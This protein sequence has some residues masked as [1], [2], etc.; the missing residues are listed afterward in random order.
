MLLYALIRDGAVAEF[1][2]LAEPPAA[3]KLVDGLPMLRPVVDEKP[4]TFDGKTEAMEGPAYIVEDARVVRR[5]TKRALT[6]EELD[7]R[8]EGRIDGADR[9]LFEIAFRQ[10][11]RLR[12]LEGKAA[13]TAAQFRTAIK[14]LL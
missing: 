5:W 9:L 2:R 12:A 1:R 6:A 10:E 7:A 8:K 13:L 3:V 14:A 11:N 4:E